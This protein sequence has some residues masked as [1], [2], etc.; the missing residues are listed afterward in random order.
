MNENLEFAD[1]ET[2]DHLV[3]TTGDA[4]SHYP[5]FPF[6]NEGFD[7]TP[8]S[9]YSQQGALWTT[10][11]YPPVSPAT[12]E[13]S[14]CDQTPLLHTGHMAGFEGG[15]LVRTPFYPLYNDLFSLFQYL[16][17][18]PPRS[19]PFDVS[20]IDP[21][22]S[23]PCAD[24]VGYYPYDLRPLG[25]PSP[26][27]AS[28]ATPEPIICS[29]CPECYEPYIFKRRYELDRH[30]K[31]Q[32]RC[33]HP[34]CVQLK[35]PNKKQKLEHERIHNEG[36][37]G[38]FCG[39]CSLKGLPPKPLVR[40][41][42][43]MKHSQATHHTPKDLEFL[44]C[45]LK[46]CFF[47]KGCVGIYFSSHHDLEEHFVMQHALHSSRGVTPDDKN[48]SEAFLLFKAEGCICPIYVTDPCA[49]DQSFPKRLSR[50]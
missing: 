16:E 22:G 26:F 46:P 44:Q 19:P 10:L 15:D 27:I 7:I 1:Q 18:S 28:S 29:E 35:F 5:H 23:F 12:S 34:D 41:E 24:S 2:A 47:G 31:E 42:K 30:I 36:G 33:T 39:S 45:T 4:H 20:A 32:H 40:M 9:C 25:V 21:P 43:L 13:P 14:S 3:N 8:P 50:M 37:L 48:N 17:G 38:F 11:R 49:Q 6:W